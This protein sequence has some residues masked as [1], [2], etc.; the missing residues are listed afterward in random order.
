M[1]PVTD[2]FK[3]K[4]QPENTE[5]VSHPF[6]LVFEEVNDDHTATRL[7]DPCHVTNHIGG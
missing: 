7:D 6:L 2:V 5:F 4:A 1:K 3:R